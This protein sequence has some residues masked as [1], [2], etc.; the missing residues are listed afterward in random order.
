MWIGFWPRGP[1]HEE[2]SVVPRDISKVV[3]SGDG[4][5]SHRDSRVQVGR[6]GSAGSLLDHHAGLSRRGYN[7]GR[8]LTFNAGS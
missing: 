7:F 5:G 8:G 2:E 1:R 6:N 4:R 3:V